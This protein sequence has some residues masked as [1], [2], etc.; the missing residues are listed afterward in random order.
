ME[1]ITTIISAFIRGISLLFVFTTDL[2]EAVKSIAEKEKQNN[3]IFRSPILSVLRSQ[4]PIMELK[5]MDMKQYQIDMEKLFHKNQLIPRIKSEFTSADFNF[6]NHMTKH[7]IDHDFGFDLL[8]QMVLHK[9]ATVPV[10]VGILRKHFRD[11]QNGSQMTADA[12]LKCVKAD[13]VDWN[14]SLRQFIVRFDISQD[15]QDDLD[16]YQYPLPMIVEPKKIRTN[17]DTGY[18][19]SHNSVILKNNHHDEDVCLDHLNKVNGIKLKI[20]HTTAVMIQNEW[21][22][23]DKPKP[24]EDRKEY[25][26]RV[27]A[28][29]KY[30]RTARDVMAHLEVAGNEFYL[31]HKYDKRGRIYAQGYHV[32]YQGNAW[33]KAVVEFVNQEVV[34]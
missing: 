15:V 4:T 16:R 10:L 9:R 7:N 21:K 8:V 25:Q 14:P 1:L 18:F 30:D 5:P 6:R 31:T 17:E 28:F 3:P 23:L 24:G 19:T 22:H 29:E 2:M 13:L 32:N 26:R 20:N 27:K 12:I 34:Q 11:Y 33:N